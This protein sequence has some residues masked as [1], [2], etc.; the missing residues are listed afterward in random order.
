MITKKN[1]NYILKGGLIVW[2]LWVFINYFIHHP[3]FFYAISRPPYLKTIITLLIITMGTAFYLFNKKSYTLRGWK[4]YIFLLLILMII[5]N[6]FVS[7]TQLFSSSLFKHQLLFLTNN[8]LLHLGTVFIFMCCFSIGYL[9]LKRFNNIL[10]I[11]HKSIISIAI[12]MALFT[13]ILMILAAIGYL[14]TMVVI[15]ITILLLVWQRKSCWAFIKYIFWNP[16]NTKDSSPWAYAIVMIILIFTAFNLIGAMKVFPLGYD[17]ARLYQNITKTLID[18]QMLVKGGQAYSWPLFTSLGPLL[19]KSMVF[20]IFLSHSIGILCLW[21]MFHLGRIFLDKLT[22]WIAVAIFYTLPALSF[23]LFVDEK[24]DL[25]FLFVGTSIVILFMKYGAS[26]KYDFSLQGK[27]SRWFFSILGILLGFAMGIKYLSLLLI[28]GVFSI[29]IYQ[30]GGIKAYL[31]AMFFALAGLFLLK[32]YSFGYLE[33]SSIEQYSIVGVLLF[34]GFLILVLNYKIFNWK[35]GALVGKNLLIISTVLVLSFMPWAIKNAVESGNFSSK[36][37]LYGKTT[38]NKF[39]H[40][41]LFL[42]E[43]NISFNILESHKKQVLEYLGKDKENINLDNKTFLSHYKN[44]KKDKKNTITT[45]SK[46]NTGKREEILR[47]LGYEP[48]LNKYLSLPYD[49][50]MGINIPNKRGL[51]IGFLFLLFL[52][53]L[54]LSLKQ[55]KILNLRNSIGVIAFVIVLLLSWNSV[56]YN[57]TSSNIADYLNNNNPISSSG[58]SSFG[59]ALYFP[60]LSLQNGIST[61][62]QP[63]FS[64]FSTLSFPFILFTLIAFCFLVGWIA[65]DN[66]KKL[67]QPVKII[68]LFIL[69]YGLLWWILG[70]GITYYALFLWMLASLF[71]AY[72]HQNINLFVSEE[73][74]P[75]VKKWAQISFA[76]LL[77]FN[78]LIHFSNSNNKWKYSNNIF[79]APFITHYSN[80]LITNDNFKNSKVILTEAAKMLNKDL[81]TKIYKV[82]TYINYHI[83]DNQSRVY[84]DDQLNLFD[85]TSKILQNPDDFLKVLKSNGVKYIVFSLDVASIDQTP[86]KSL[87]DKATRIVK[88]LNNKEKIR[89]VMTDNKVIRYNSETKKQTTV[90]GLVGKTVKKGRIAI[91]ELL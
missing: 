31:I 16:I 22:A 86:E 12:G 32:I 19:F 27:T 90:S 67:I 25:S 40:D 7:E 49:I 50:T 56:I 66:W 24:V 77:A 18:T 26:I 55:K 46:K 37:L 13:F 59:N 33:I 9:F 44:S 45:Q 34:L 30:W 63:V 36:N 74:T 91:F 51:N 72:Y 23:H 6:S 48:G 17:G 64:L 4:I 87:V 21:A 61:L 52:P 47:Y 68:V 83:K 78:L 43:N 39:K 1:K 70:N 60:F 71:I 11:H 28:V 5:Y 53:L 35:K 65:K 3:S 2:A 82:G 84:E 58:L 76:I 73:L 8:I 88:V 79:F 14:Q 57:E 42:S 80:H 15:P 29:I 10:N 85:Q 75:F 81:T 20:S 41:Y 62:T 38:L 69:S 54:I 89:L